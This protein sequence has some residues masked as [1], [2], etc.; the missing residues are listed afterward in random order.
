MLT[1]ACLKTFSF[2]YFY[3]CLNPVRVRA[4]LDASTETDQALLHSIIAHE[5]RVELAFENKR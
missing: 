5:R 1:L 2:F 4:G 3:Y